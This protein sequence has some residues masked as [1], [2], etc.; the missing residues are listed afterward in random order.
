MAVNQQTN[1]RQIVVLGVETSQVNN[2]VT[3]VAGPNRAP[4]RRLVKRGIV[5]DVMS[6]TDE[7]KL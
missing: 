2:T 4:R 5:A 7:G 3:M 6:L 1:K